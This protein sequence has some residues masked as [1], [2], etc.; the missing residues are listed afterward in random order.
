M[1]DLAMFN[2]VLTPAEIADLA[3]HDLTGFGFEGDAISCVRLHARMHACPALESACT[4]SCALLFVHAAG[5]QGDPHFTGFRGQKYDVLV[6]DLPL[7]A[8]C[9][10]HGHV[11][12]PRAACLSVQGRVNTTYL[13]Y[14]DSDVSVTG[15]LSVNPEDGKVGTHL[16][17][18][19][20]TWP[21]R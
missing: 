9:A 6:R 17:V 10:T 13:W 3:S 18:P 2:R 12:L 16:Q 11:S 7:P 4:D 19:A 20:H 14:S 15:V 5:S 8:C 1:D 21:S